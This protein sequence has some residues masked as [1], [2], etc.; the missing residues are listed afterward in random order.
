MV[1]ILI[2][3]LKNLVHVRANLREDPLPGH[4]PG[5]LPPNIPVQSLLSEGWLSKVRRKS[6]VTGANPRGEESGLVS[7]AEMGGRDAQQQL[8]AGSLEC[9][10]AGVEGRTATGLEIGLGGP[11]DASST[12]SAAAPR[13]LHFSPEGSQNS[14]SDAPIE[15]QT[16]QDTL[17]PAQGS[18]VP[19]IVEIG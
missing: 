15:S 1:D 11:S 16:L 6:S 2:P 10:A 17:A 14:S 8:A 7:G 19:G 12:G 13:A 18:A 9:V 5:L 4:S 3:T